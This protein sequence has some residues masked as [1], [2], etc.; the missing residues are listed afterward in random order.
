MSQ[1]NKLL[2]GVEV[3]W[4]TLGEVCDFQNGFAFQSSLFKETGLPIVRITNIDGLNVNLE[5]VKYFNPDDYKSGN[6]LN[7]FVEKGDVLIAMSGATTGKIGYY[8]L[9]DK[10]YINQR[11][12]KFIPDKKIL[13]NRFLYH[14]ILTKSLFLYALAGGGAQ[15]NLSSN[16]I[17]EKLQIPIPP[18]NVQAEIVRILD[19]FTELI[20]ELTTEL[21]A[22]KKQY[23]YYRDRLLSFPSLSEL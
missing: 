6:P 8:N 16:M 14:F 3:E 23:E 12:G 1:L 11:V 4:R 2:E 20:T 17:K 21:T 22:R 9:N 5:D 7:Y 10:A 19:T 13:N 18:L 15:P